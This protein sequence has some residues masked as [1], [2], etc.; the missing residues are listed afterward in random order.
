MLTNAF[1]RR[2]MT[3]SSVFVRTLPFY[4]QQALFNA[5]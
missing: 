2:V 5:L 1:N 3:T 4:E